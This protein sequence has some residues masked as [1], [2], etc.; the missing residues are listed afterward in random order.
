MPIASRYNLS[1]PTLPAQRKAIPDGALTC[2]FTV[3]ARQL[4]S[5]SSERREQRDRNSQVGNHCTRLLAGFDQAY[6]QMNVNARFSELLIGLRD[7]YRLGAAFG[8]SLS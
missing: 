3:P 1:A 7:N 5:A 8:T 6:Q 4:R 2:Q